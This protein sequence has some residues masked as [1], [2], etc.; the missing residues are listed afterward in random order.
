MPC[1]PYPDLFAFEGVPI[2]QNIVEQTLASLPPHSVLPAF[3]FEMPLVVP[4]VQTAKHHA[5]PPLT[6][7]PGVTR[8]QPR[9]TAMPPSNVARSCYK[10]ATGAELWIA[11]GKDSSVVVPPTPSVRFTQS[12]PQKIFSFRNNTAGSIFTLGPNLTN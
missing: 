9:A 5:L 10:G 7:A 8:T 6:T 11:D 1:F 12:L 4:P 3:P 2:P